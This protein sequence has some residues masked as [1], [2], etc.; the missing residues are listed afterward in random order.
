MSMDAPSFNNPLSFEASPSPKMKP[1]SAAEA[2]LT[3]DSI[4][5]NDAV[6]GS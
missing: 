6:R 5:N 4:L 1:M 3:P 2:A